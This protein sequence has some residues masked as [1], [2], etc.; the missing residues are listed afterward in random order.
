MPR[1]TNIWDVTP[2]TAHPRA[3]QLL[4][5]SIML[6]QLYLRKGMAYVPTV[7]Q[8]GAGFYTN[9]EPVAVVPVTDS[10]A[11]ENAIKIAMSKGNPIVPTPTRDAFP[12]PVVL[13]YA[14]VKSWSAF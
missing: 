13:E 1:F 9:I 2:E 3:R 4:G 12:K 11:L 5:Q 6:W 10:G 14:K 8:T 7:A